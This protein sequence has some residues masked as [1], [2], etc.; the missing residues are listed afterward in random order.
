MLLCNMFSVDVAS[1][2]VSFYLRLFLFCLDAFYTNSFVA[3]YW[4]IFQLDFV[5]GISHRAYISTYL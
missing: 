5:L 2:F 1:L 4:G 3:S